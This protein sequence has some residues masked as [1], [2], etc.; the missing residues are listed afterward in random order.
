M[1][2]LL[3]KNH[4]SLL[5]YQ[6]CK[7][8]NSYVWEMLPFPSQSREGAKTSLSRGAFA[9]TSSTFPGVV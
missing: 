8:R 4:S 1:H 6:V 5:G 2:Y 7:L 9:L 3:Q